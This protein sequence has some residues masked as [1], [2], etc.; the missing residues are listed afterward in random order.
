M[1]LDSRF[2]IATTTTA[3]LTSVAS[4]TSLT[5]QEQINCQRGFEAVPGDKCADIDECEKNPNICGRTMRCLNTL[6]S[7]RYA[8]W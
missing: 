7:Y 6:G 8:V 2:D 3:K 4:T 5:S 1:V